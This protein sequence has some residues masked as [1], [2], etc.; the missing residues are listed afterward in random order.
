MS[1]IIRLPDMCSESAM[2][3]YRL[4][5]TEE[6][7][8]MLLPIKGWMG[9]VGF[10]NNNEVLV[11]CD[12]FCIIHFVGKAVDEFLSKLKENNQNGIRTKVIIGSPHRYILMSKNECIYSSLGFYTRTV[13]KAEELIE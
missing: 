8:N 7:L 6:Y 4:D 12:D 11:K 10:L 2:N 5:N 3:S 13:F 1:R 9:H